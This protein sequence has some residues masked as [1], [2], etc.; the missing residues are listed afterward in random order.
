MNERDYNVM[1][2]PSLVH[3]HEYKL[4]MNVIR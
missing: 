3:K 2:I 1:Q 4:I